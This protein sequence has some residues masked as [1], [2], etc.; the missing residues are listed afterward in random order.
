MFFPYGFS[1]QRELGETL[2]LLISGN[3]EELLIP[4]RANF[5]SVAATLKLPAERADELS[6]FVKNKNGWVFLQVL[7]PFM[8]DVQQPR[9][10][11]GDVMRR[12]PRIFVRQLRPIM[13]HFVLMLPAADD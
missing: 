12:L 7:A 4:F 11:N 5:K 2:Y 8:D 6:L 1:L 13:Q 10:I 3:V 9:G